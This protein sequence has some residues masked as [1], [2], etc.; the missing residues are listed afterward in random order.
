M[1]NLNTAHPLRFETIPGIGS[2][3]RKS[4]ASNRPYRSFDDLLRVHRIGS[5]RRDLIKKHAFIQV[6]IKRDPFDKSKHVFSYETR[7]DY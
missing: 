4:I 5:K 2:K 7:P 3:L 1:F 6:S